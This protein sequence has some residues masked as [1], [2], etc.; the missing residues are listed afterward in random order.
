ME[1]FGDPLVGDV[2][3]ELPGFCDAEVVGGFEEDCC[4]SELE[5]W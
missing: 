1:G 3:E 5:Q 4:G 2:A